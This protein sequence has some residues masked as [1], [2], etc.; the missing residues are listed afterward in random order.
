MLSS[1]SFRLC[2]LIILATGCSDSTH[3]GAPTAPPVTLPPVSPPASP[4]VNP[5]PE[6]P[7]LSRPGEIF[8]GSDELYDVGLAYHGSHLGTRYVLYD[9]TTFGLQFSSYNFGFFE[10]AGHYSTAGSGLMFTFDAEPRWQATGILH[11]DSLSISYNDWAMLSDF[12]DG[13][14]VRSP[15]P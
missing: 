4:A 7:P 3:S 2:F 5:T 6:F 1:F 10:Y 13:V 15:G 12:I 9:S 11:G 14:Y 8:N